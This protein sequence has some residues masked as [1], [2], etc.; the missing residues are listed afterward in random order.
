M[1]SRRAARGC[2]TVLGTTVFVSLLSGF[3]L[4]FPPLM[5]QTSTHPPPAPTEQDASPS[6]A[7]T[8][9]PAADRET[10][11]KSMSRHPLPKKGC[12]KASYPRTEWQEVP[13]MAPSRSMN[14]LQRR[15]GKGPGPNTVGGMGGDFTA[16]SSGL[17]SS[18]VGL[19]KSVDGATS[20]QGDVQGLAPMVNNVFSLQ[21]NTQSPGFSNP[22]IC[23]AVLGG[24]QGVQQFLFSQTQC[25]YEP[26]QG[27][28]SVVPGTAPCVFMEYWLVAYGATCPPNWQTDN[29]GDCWLNSPSVYVP[30]QTIAAGLT[31]MAKADE[32]GLDTVM[33]GT[34]G[35]LYAQ[36]NDSILNLSQFWNTAEFNV[37]GDGYSTVANFPTPSTIVIKTSIDDT[38]MNA[39]SCG[40]SSSTAETNS[41]TLAPTAAP[42]CCH[43]DG[44]SPS[45]EFME[46]NADHTATCGRTALEGEPHATTADGTHYNF[47][48]AGE[49]ISL[50][51]P[52]GDEIQTR[53]KPIPTTYILTDA[54]DGLTSCV[55]IN[56]AVAARVG[57]HRVTWEPNLSGVPD[58]SGLQLRIDGALTTLGPQGMAL[59]T[60]G[61]VAPQA[62]GALEVDFPDGKTLLATPQWWDGIRAWYLNVDVSNLGL[63]S[64]DS[65][66]SDWG[67]TG[68]IADGSWLPALPNGSSMG[69]MPAPLHDRYV[70]LYKKFADAWRVNNENSLF[71][72]APGTSTDTFTMRDWP[73]ENPPCVVRD[74]RPLEPTSEEVAQRA[75]RRVA[76]PSM[77]SNCVFDVK[78][79]GNLGFA[80]T[81]LATQRI[82]ADSTVTSLTHGADPSQAGEWVTFTAFVAPNSSAATGFPSGT[83]QFA[84]DGLN[85]GEPVTVD[86]KGRATWET[87]KLRVGTHRVT[88][89]YLP[90]ADS[91]FLPSTSLEKLQTVKRCFCDAA[92]CLNRR[93]CR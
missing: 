75:C 23:L 25:N 12:F 92:S 43:Y 15:W 73:K 78:V 61:R 54:Y 79:T 70:A 42:L 24:C 10:W 14:S 44:A 52:D 88:A 48:G 30:P 90:G 13:C 22:P 3:V 46:T 11:R 76:D 1:K 39:P 62:G 8:Q 84:V 87:S 59:G 86:A 29:M 17:I 37:F 20:V 45:I 21:L 38:T 27:E 83:V 50:R 67:I 68:P 4:P 40:T 55:S 89:S 35:N 74:E 41:L 31:L 28:Q 34:S 53:Q 71:D 72:Y 5:A 65:A 57:K 85:I 2:L 33:L 80:T 16:Q 47:Q 93:S 91:V 19:I 58:P 77:R 6:Q 36:A 81:Y 26:N 60:G 49:F 51:N 32:G 63:V 7:S 66:A 18:A 56:T 82:L 69:P 64:A 9:V